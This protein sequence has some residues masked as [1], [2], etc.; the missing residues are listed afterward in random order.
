MTEYSFNI[1]ILLN[2][3]PAFANFLQILHL[4]TLSG[5]MKALREGV[6]AFAVMR[7]SEV[8]LALPQAPWQGMVCAFARRHPS[9]ASTKAGGAESAVAH[10]STTISDRTRG[11]AGLTTCGNDAGV[12]SPW[13]P[14]VG[15]GG[16]IVS[17]TVGLMQVAGLMPDRPPAKGDAG[18]EE[19][20]LRVPA[21][22]AA[23]TAL[24]G[25]GSVE[26]EVSPSNLADAATIYEY[27]QMGHTVTACDVI[28]CLGSSDLRVATYAAE[29]FER[30]V[31]PKIIFSGGIGTGPHSGS[32]LLG[33]TRPEAVVMAEE[34]RRC[35]VP[36]DA[37]LV[38][39][40]SRNSGENIRFVH[41]FLKRE[42]LLD[43]TRRIVV[44]QKPFMERCA[45]ET[46]ATNVAPLTLLLPP[47]LSP[48]PVYT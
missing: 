42:G 9:T 22:A 4:Q 31:A 39:P 29:L 14:D 34:A 12:A 7:A 16:V 11:S 40:R 23:A 45:R 1:M 37:I 25:A 2:E 21:A 5:S 3:Y 18:E 35:G 32:N 26:M 6:S 24:S 30:G 47:L 38:E 41:A 19:E 28:I 8:G 10:D 13:A 20:M 48:V 44:V 36:S 43:T 46:C 33:W 17:L 15:D 27:M